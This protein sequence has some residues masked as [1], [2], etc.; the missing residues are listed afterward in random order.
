[1][2][3]F[4]VL[5]VVEQLGSGMSRILYFYERVI[6]EISDYFIKVNFLF[7]VPDEEMMSQFA[8]II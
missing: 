6:F 3:V 1:M 8:I 7:S 4:K 2:R 5:G